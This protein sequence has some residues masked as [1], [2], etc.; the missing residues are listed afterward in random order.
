M[1][2]MFT[3]LSSEYKWVTFLGVLCFYSSDVLNKL[4]VIV[5]PFAKLPMK[6]I[7]F[8]RI[9]IVTCMQTSNKSILLWLT[10]ER[11]RKFFNRFVYFLR[12]CYSKL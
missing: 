6:N 2:V 4:L 11:H 3:A 7:P 10:M 5:V 12:L 8:W 9:L 1:I